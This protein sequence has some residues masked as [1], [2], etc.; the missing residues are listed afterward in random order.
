MSDNLTN[1]TNM[2]LRDVET[3]SKMMRRYYRTVKETMRAM[4]GYLPKMCWWPGKK[5]LARHIWMDSLHAD[6]LRSRTLD[7]RYPRVDVEDNDDVHL[8]SILEKLPTAPT[9]EQFLNSVYDVIKPEIVKALT[10]YLQNSDP[11]DDAPTHF[12]FRRIIDEIGMQLEEY[13]N[14]MK[15]FRDFTNPE[16]VKWNHLVRS[17]LFSCGGIDGPDRQIDPFAA[18]FVERP[19]YELPLEGGRD[20]SWEKAVVQVSPRAARNFTEEQIR[21]AIDH[22]NE[23]W[24]SETP[25][26]LIWEYK[27]MSWELYFWAARWCYDE[28]RHAAM[29]VERLTAMGLEVGV[30]YPM[31]PDHWRAFR[32]RGVKYLL[33]LLHRLEQGGP[34]GKAKWKKKFIEMNDLAAAQDCDYDWADESG[35]IS[36]GVAWL[37][38]V[39]P[40]W[41]KE[42]TIDEGNK[43]AS[44]WGAWIGNHHK[45]GTHG[46][47]IFLDRMDRKMEA[48]SNSSGK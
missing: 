12:Y 26:A 8:L 13:Q 45:N 37:K 42:R 31:V 27:N 21:V 30:D 36:Y 34:M 46:Y 16:A 4:A 10:Q 9:D 20:T 22:A 25:A 39:F 47:E 40:E 1:K 23:V 32:E 44:E 41:S 6:M 19:A 17:A 18:S 48:L 29:G 38:A 3:A 24:A 35:H 2:K 33:L 5:L 15:D 14:I 43:I 28:M 11:L 7:L